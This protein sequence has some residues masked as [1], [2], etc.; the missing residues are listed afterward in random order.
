MPLPFEFAA[1]PTTEEAIEVAIAVAT[2]LELSR[3]DP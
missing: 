1:D 2:L 3:V